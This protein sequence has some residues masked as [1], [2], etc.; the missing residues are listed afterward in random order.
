MECAKAG[1][2]WNRNLPTTSTTAVDLQPYT[3]SDEE[4]PEEAEAEGVDVPAALLMSG[5]SLLGV[6]WSEVEAKREALRAEAEALQVEKREMA[7]ER[8]RLSSPGSGGSRVYSTAL[9]PP[10]MCV[11]LFSSSHL[12]GQSQPTCRGV[13]EAAAHEACC[14]QYAA[15]GE[16][17]ASTTP[18]LLYVSMLQRVPS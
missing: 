10:R 2:H 8:G 11:L 18:L 15:V 9:S 17:C 1:P 5:S 7:A 12:H 14:G 13:G 3:F 4:Q 6:G 16:E